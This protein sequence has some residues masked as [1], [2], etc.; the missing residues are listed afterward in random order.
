MLCLV[1]EIYEALLFVCIVDFVVG[2]H[3][4]LFDL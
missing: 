2:V 3:I 4:A 1:Y